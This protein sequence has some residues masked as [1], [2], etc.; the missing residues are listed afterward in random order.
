LYV[1]LSNIDKNFRDPIN[2]KIYETINKKS[3]TQETWNFM[4]TTEKEKI[5]KKKT[6]TIQSDSNTTNTTIL[7]NNLN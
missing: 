3:F 4:Y 2:R 6:K 1:V 7:I 5:E